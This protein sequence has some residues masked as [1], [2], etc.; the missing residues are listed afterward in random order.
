[1]YRLDVAEYVQTCAGQSATFTI[2][3]RLRNPLYT[4]NVRARGR[5]SPCLA[6]SVF[7][8]GRQR[9]GHENDARSSGKM[10]SLLCVILAVAPAS[11]RAQS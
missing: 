11:T 10:F 8:G 1:M 5:L 6:L 4:G 7:C 3:R 2:A 9:P